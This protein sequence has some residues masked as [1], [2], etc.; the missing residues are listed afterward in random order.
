M[1][2]TARSI[3]AQQLSNC[4]SSSAPSVSALSANPR[5]IATLAFARALTSGS[6]ITRSCSCM[7]LFFSRGGQSGGDE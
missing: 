1:P 6:R 5:S 3:L 7:G 4:S 2:R